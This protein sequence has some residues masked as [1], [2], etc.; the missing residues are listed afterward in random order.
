[1]KELIDESQA[2]LI[3]AFLSI[4]VFLAPLAW[5]LYRNRKVAKNQ[6]KILWAYASLCA[7]LGPAIWIF[8]QVYNSIENEYGL[9]SLKALKYNFFIMVGIVVLF[10]AAYFFLTRMLQQPQ[11][12]RRRK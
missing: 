10:F 3:I 6:K 7:A 2:N 5:A 12:L 8:W 4:V 9:D 11:V 1:M